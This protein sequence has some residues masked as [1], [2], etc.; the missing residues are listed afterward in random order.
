MKLE[1]RTRPDAHE[2]ATSSMGRASILLAVSRILRDTSFS[3][4]RGHLAHIFNPGRAMEPPCGRRQ[5]TLRQKTEDE[6]VT[7]SIATQSTDLWDKGP[8][9]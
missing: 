1:K 7:F 8:C 2:K 9:L 3:R 5:K 6:D 4:S